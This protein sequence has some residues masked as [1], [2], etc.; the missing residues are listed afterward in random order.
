MNLLKINEHII[1][2][3]LMTRVK[4]EN[5]MLMIF[6]DKNNGFT[7]TGDEAQ[8]VFE[9]LTKNSQLLGEEA[10]QRAKNSKKGGIAWK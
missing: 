9:Y 8:E 4:M 2:L 1:N 5:S 7:L 10:K 3:D 6:Y